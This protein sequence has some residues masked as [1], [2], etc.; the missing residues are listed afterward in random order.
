MTKKQA[1]KAKKKAKK[2]AKKAKRKQTPVGIRILKIIVIILVIAI[3]VFLIVMGVTKFSE[4]SYVMGNVSS[5]VTAINDG[6]YVDDI[7]GDSDTEEAEDTNIG[8]FVPG[9][10]GGIDFESIDD[11][12]NYYVECYDYTK[13]LMADYIDEDGNTVSFY[14]LLGDENLIIGDILIDGKQNPII[15]DLVPTLMDSLYTPGLFGLPPC[16]NRDPALDVDD[17]G[18]DYCTSRLSPDDIIAAT[19]EDNGD[20]TITMV[21][22]PA[23]VEMS[24]KGQDAQGKLFNTLGAID[25]VFE[26]IGV[27]SWS[28]GTTADNC[29]V[30]YENGY[31]TVKIDTSTGEITEGDYH[32]LCTLGVQHANVMVIKDK[33][34]TVII[35]Y[36]QHF[37]ATDEYLMENKGLTRA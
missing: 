17:D 10:Y 31:A 33:S 35:T 27:V 4:I 19:V 34:T 8:E 21:L 26:T 3:V 24:Y 7:N 1:K 16:N 22:Q 23:A 6:T 11:V 29:K 5:A 14:K 37:P 13:S 28:E 32:M 9:T 2:A 30:V 12:V 25:G 18:N 20:G 36:D 15:D